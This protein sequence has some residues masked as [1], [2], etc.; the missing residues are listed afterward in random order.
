MKPTVLK[1]F[2]R[3]WLELRGLEPEMIEA[4]VW[5][6][7][8]PRGLKEKLGRKELT[9][10]FTQRA[11]K[12]HPES[13]LATVGNPVFDRLL[14]VAREEGRIGI[15]YAKPPARGKRVPGLEKVGSIQG[16]MPKKGE[17]VYQAICHFVFSITYP[18]IEAPDEMEILSI[19]SG[20]L[21]PLSQ[22]PDLFQLWQKLEPIPR[23]GRTAI[24]PLPLSELMLE[25]GLKALEKRMRRRIN[26]VRQMSGKRLEQ[27]SASIEAYYQQLIEEAR[28]QSRR[29]S[30]KLE[31]REDRIKWLQLE[32]KRRIEEANEFWKPH[33]NAHFVGLGLEMVPR[34]AFKYP[35]PTAKGRASTKGPVRLWDET[36]GTLL[37]PFCAKCGKAG[38][39]D[40]AIVTPAD[41]RC[42]E[43]AALPPDPPK[44]KKKRAT[45]KSSAKAA[46]PVLD[47]AS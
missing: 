11:L 25:T 17:S 12:K 6:L 9:L 22:T 10:S 14:G 27:E 40:P 26:K 42:S 31:D 38:L 44:P 30:T 34:V 2:V 21:E 36:S 43:C 15:G 7:S 18:S 33:V 35:V 1:A 24:V 16:V 13:E 3:D 5:R 20:T 47:Q 37:S 28:N 29:W 45:K 39:E 8:V 4:D 23:R 41:F 32:W 46:A 19:D